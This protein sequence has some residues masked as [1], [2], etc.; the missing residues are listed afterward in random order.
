MTL[1]QVFVLVLAGVAGIAGL[2][3]AA[4]SRGGAGELIGL[5]IFVAA[6]VYVFAGIKRHFDQIDAGH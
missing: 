5:A 4:A 1:G 3:L 2:F 6:V